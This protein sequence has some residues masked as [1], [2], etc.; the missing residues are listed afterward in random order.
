MQ[1]SAGCCAGEAAQLVESAA[2][3]LHHTHT[4][5]RTFNFA[6]PTA[7]A[8]FALSRTHTLTHTHRYPKVLTG[9]CT[10][11]LFVARPS[12]W[13]GVAPLARWLRLLDALRLGTTIP[14]HCLQSLEPLQ[15]PSLLLL[16][17]PGRRHSYHLPAASCCQL[18]GPNEASKLPVTARPSGA[19]RDCG[20]CTS[21]D[22]GELITEAPLRSI[23][24][25]SSVYVSGF[26]SID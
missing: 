10:P 14:R 2:T 1:G 16:L 15:L 5:T 26:A 18:R 9:T 17:L 8:A 7:A 20:R 13:G 4:H 24:S 11:T 3:L 19:L 23:R 6:T 22:R 12:K 21:A 25:P